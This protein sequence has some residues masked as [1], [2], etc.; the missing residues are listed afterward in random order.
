M[1]QN[2]LRKSVTLMGLLLLGSLVSIP[3]FAQA[4]TYNVT[5]IPKLVGV[6]WFS[7]MEKGLHDFAKKDGGIKFSVAGAPDTDPAAQARI[8]EDAIAKRPDAIVVVPNDN[9]V[10]EPLMKK[11]MDAGIKMI[12]QEGASIQNSIANIEFLILEKEGKDL[13]DLLVKKAGKK[14]GYAIM[15]GGLT[16]Q[17]HNDRADAVVAYQEKNFPGLHQVTSRLEGSENVQQARDRTL[18]L[19][20]AYPDLVGII[21]IGSLGGVGGAQAVAEKNLKGKLSLIGIVVPSQAK[22]L[23]QSGNL[24]ANYIGNPYRIGKDTAFITKK[25][26]NGVEL[27][28]VGDLPE[29]GTPLVK[30]KDIIF[31][32]DTEVT[33]ENADSFGF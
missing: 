27:S 11:G 33:V 29:Y 23:L 32:A 8:L 1:K 14:G 21:Y 3:A 25:L 20:T 10:L 22:K 6:P 31:H 2:S 13:V 12:S 19:I 7:A 4:K 15:V 18:Q 26:L 17:G 28:K 5:F 16:V 9:K 30:G 24:A